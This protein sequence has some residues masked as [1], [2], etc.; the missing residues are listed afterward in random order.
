MCKT[1]G[2]LG[3]GKAAGMGD[4]LITLAPVGEVRRCHSGEDITTMKTLA[5]T[6]STCK[7]ELAHYQAVEGSR[8]AVSHP[9]LT[10]IACHSL[11]HELHT[12]CGLPEFDHIASRMGQG[13]RISKFYIS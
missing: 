2:P 4:A 3:I 1:G 7:L 12:P 11:L 5:Y 13:P 10:L 8:V 9:D 6:A